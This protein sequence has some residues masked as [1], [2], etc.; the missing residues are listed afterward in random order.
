MPKTYYVSGT[1][2][3]HAT[4]LTELT[5]FRNLQ[6]AAD[7]V[8]AG[9][10]VFVMNGT[11]TGIYAN[12]LNL[13]N[14][15]GTADAP[16]TFT[17][18]PG[19]K[20]V[21]EAHKNNWNAIAV[22]GCS[23]IVIDGLTL[24][25]ARDKIT[26][27]YAL[28]EKTNLNNPATSGNGISITLL[29]GT[30]NK[31]SHYITVKN[32][33]VANFPGGGITAMYADYITVENNV[34]SGNAWYSP[35][36]CQG[37]TIFESW[38]SD[39]NATDYKIV[40]KGNI[41]FD[42]KSLVPWIV[43]GIITEGH[44]IMLDTSYFG[45]VAYLGKTLIAN[46]LAYN[47][48]GAGI[49]IFKGGNPVDIVNNTTYQNSTELPNGEIF[50]NK[51]QNVSCRENIFYA[52]SG[53]AATTIINSAK[54]AFDKNLIWGKFTGAGKENI[55]NKDPLFVNAPKDFSLHPETPAKW[56]EVKQELRLVD[57]EYPHQLGFKVQ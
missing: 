1:G 13:A 6:K 25:G 44:G 56:I 32:C 36:G 49:Q 24:A 19:H 33:K 9:D 22:N 14:K 55:L 41:S 3:D 15:H 47:N 46:N 17:A 30:P 4:G 12:I 18:Y 38:N 26:L 35:Y 2:S 52:K 34:V 53:M 16:I 54:I 20:P 45:D 23:Y 31:H 28:Q 39:N 37:I 11:Y 8:Q 50:L 10:T 48:G 57:V 40:I 7:L 43:P 5:A 51:A 29:R 27:E 42:N 21:L